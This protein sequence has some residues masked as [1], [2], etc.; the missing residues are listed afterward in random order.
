[1][2]RPFTGLRRLFEVRMMVEKLELRPPPRILQILEKLRLTDIAPGNICPDRETLDK[3][4]EMFPSLAGD[5]T[6]I[7]PGDDGN[8]QSWR[9]DPGWWKSLIRRG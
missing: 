1:M 2:A 3:L 9:N 6:A 8:C 7:G 4:Y 5:G